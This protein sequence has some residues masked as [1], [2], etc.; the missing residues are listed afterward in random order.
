VSFWRLCNYSGARMRF[1]LILSALLTFTLASQAS[2]FCKQLIK[3]NGQTV[4]HSNG[5]VATYSAGTAGATWYFDNGQVMT[6][7]ALTNGSTTYHLNGNILSYSTGT[8]GATWYYDNNNVMSY[9]MG[10][11]GATVY[12]ENGSVMT[13]SGPELSSK[14][15]WEEACELA[16]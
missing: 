13:Y 11:S 5:Q 12:Y 10:N 4:Y 3:G 8:Q 16:F 2:M 9:S 6:Y 7:S 15:L 14:E 1:F